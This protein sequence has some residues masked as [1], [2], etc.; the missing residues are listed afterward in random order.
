MPLAEMDKHVE[1]EHTLSLN[2]TLTLMK[3]NGSVAGTSNGLVECKFKE[4]GCDH[5]LQLD[6]L[7]RHMDSNVHHHL[8]VY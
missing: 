3:L 5:V 1:V 2:G 8:Q 4:V 7:P 6:Q